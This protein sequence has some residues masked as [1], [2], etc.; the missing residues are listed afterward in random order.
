MDSTLPSSQLDF[1]LHLTR[2]LQANAYNFYIHNYD[3]GRPRDKKNWL[4]RIVLWIQKAITVV[5]KKPKL[6]FLAYPDRRDLVALDFYLSHVPDIAR[7][8]AVLGD[9]QSRNLL[10]SLVAYRILGKERITLPLAT[11][12]YSKVRRSLRSLETGKEAIFVKSMN[13][14]LFQNDLKPLGYDLKIFAPRGGVHVAFV[15]RQYEYLGSTP[16]FKVQPGDVVIDAGAGFGDTSFRFAYET[17][18]AGKV[19]AFEFVPSNIEIIRRTM[20]L[21]PSVSPRIEIVERPVWSISDKKVDFKDSGASTRIID[22]PIS[23]SQFSTRTVSIDDWVEEA[24]IKAVHL[25]KMDIEGAELEAL[26][27]AVRTLN[28]FKPKLAISL[29]HR[30]EDY[31]TIPDFLQSLD[32]GYRFYLGHYTVFEYETVLYVIV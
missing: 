20:Q 12:D 10:V 19:Y 17:G 30:P 7:L 5:V 23:P 3:I 25:I 18:E 24:G 13:M 6:V 1:L 15:S 32:L 26:K 11:K 4:Q 27:G 8:Y 2:T 14:W 31:W 29:Y 22:N 28:R 21:N 16:P 9:E